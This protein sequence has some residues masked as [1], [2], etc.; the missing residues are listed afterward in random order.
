MAISDFSVPVLDGGDVLSF[1]NAN[2]TTAR[3]LVDQHP[4]SVAVGS[5]TTVGGVRITDIIISSNDS[6]TD[7]VALWESKLLTTQGQAASVVYGTANTTGAI[8]A[9]TTTLT[10]ATGDWRI[11]GWKIGDHVMVF[12]PRNGAANASDGVAGIVS[13]VTATVLTVSASTFSAET[14]LTGSH[15]FRVARR[16]NTAVEAGSGYTAGTSPIR[17][18]GNTEDDQSNDA[19]GISIGPNDVLIASMQVAVSGSNVV[20]VIAKWALK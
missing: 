18:L 8:T 11:D 16:S 1:V 13:A 17:V 9:T 7:Y 10:R 6:V 15:I 19:N 5:A 2:G 14:L 20:D 3:V 12:A 4:A